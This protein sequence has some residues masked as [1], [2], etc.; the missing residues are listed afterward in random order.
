MNVKPRRPSQNARCERCGGAELVAIPA[1]AIGCGIAAREI[2]DDVI[3]TRCGH[4][5]QPAYEVFYDDDNSGN[6][7][8]RE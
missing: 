1:F 3:C 4:M 5:G 2:A 7:D 8:E 6:R